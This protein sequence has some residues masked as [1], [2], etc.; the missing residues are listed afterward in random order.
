MTENIAR[1]NYI[2]TGSITLELPG[3]LH[4]AFSELSEFSWVPSGR[5]SNKW[6]SSGDDG[7]CDGK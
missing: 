2:D 3:S 7:L 4:E 6:L 5:S 1:V